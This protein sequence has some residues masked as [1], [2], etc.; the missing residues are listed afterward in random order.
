MSRSESGEWEI[1]LLLLDHG[2]D[3]KGR[4]AWSCRGFA[5]SLQAAS[6][7]VNHELIKF[8]LD[9]GADINEQNRSWVFGPALEVAFYHGHMEVVQLLFQEG[10]DL[11][12]KAG[13]DE[14]PLEATQAESHE[15]IVQLFK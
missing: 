4:A 12:T 5:K 7:T 2:A 3:I 15:E 8:V 14:I 1:R 9:S 13:N 10:A 11:R 6:F